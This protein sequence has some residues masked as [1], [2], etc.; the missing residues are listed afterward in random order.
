MDEDRSEQRQRL[1]DAMQEDREEIAKQRQQ[2]AEEKKRRLQ[3]C[4]KLKKYYERHRHASGVYKKDKSG[5]RTYLSNEQRAAAE[6]RYRKR[7]R[8]LCR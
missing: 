2:Q 4:K 6:A 1:L 5:N 8:E 7:L 3:Q